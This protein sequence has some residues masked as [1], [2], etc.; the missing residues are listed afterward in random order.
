MDNSNLNLENRIDFISALELKEVNK[1][2]ADLF[3]GKEDLIK[4]VSDDQKP[5]AKIDS[6]SIVSFVSNVSDYHKNAVLNTTLLAQLNSDKL[7]DRFNKDQVMDWYKNYQKV[8]SICGWTLQNFQFQNF[9]ASGSSFSINTAII[10]I[11]SA[12]IPGDEVK[13][14]VAALN[15]LSN[16][17]NDDP[18]Y[19]VWDVNTHTTNGGNF[20]IVPVRDNNE[21]INTLSMTLSSY[22][23]ETTEST[24]RFLWTDYKSS[25]TKMKYSAQTTTLNENVYMRLENTIIKK[26][27]D[28]AIQ[29]IG[30]LDI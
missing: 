18:W 22:V 3:K 7:F 15:S 19:K 10:D 8:L 25:D 26:L 5:S 20:Q 29:Q 1:E 23:F 11:L 16:L 9:E 12:V 21:E 6:G 2:I 28:R 13:I 4:A 24:L 14:V 17:K 30:D 27:G